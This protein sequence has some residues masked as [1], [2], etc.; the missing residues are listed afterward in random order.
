[1]VGIRILLWNS[2]S[3]KRGVGSS[4]T[5]LAGRTYE[6]NV[7]CLEGFGATLYKKACVLHCEKVRVPE[8]QA[9]RGLDILTGGG[10]VESRNSRSDSLRNRQALR[11]SVSSMKW[12]IA[13]STI[14]C[15]GFLWD[16]RK[17]SVGDRALNPLSSQLRP[18]TKRRFP[19]ARPLWNHGG[20][21][22]C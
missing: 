20:Q 16:G 15:G 17:M 2:G 14:S 4:G 22:E 3:D 10:G 7:Q 21:R 8:P 5:P 12:V 18:D 19:G 13:T 1:M 11:S 9:T 6:V